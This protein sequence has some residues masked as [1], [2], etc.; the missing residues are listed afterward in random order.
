[1]KKMILFIILILIV[2]MLL[3]GYF[4]N[5]DKGKYSDDTIEK[6]K[7]SVVRYINNNYK[8]IK[9]I[10]FEDGDYS[11]PMGGL[12]IGGTVNEKAGFSASVDDKTFRVRSFAEKKGFPNLK[13]VCKEKSCD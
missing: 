5:P 7:E 12:M 1:M 13:E 8:N 4:V 3:G 9:T 6:A 11:S 10:E 2:I